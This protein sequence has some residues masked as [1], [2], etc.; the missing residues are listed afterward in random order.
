M[1]I[2]DAFIIDNLRRRPRE[3]PAAP[4]ELPLEL[5]VSE[6]DRDG[7]DGPPPQPRGQEEPRPRG[8]IVLDT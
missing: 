1:P 5:P 8:V 4:A 6:H 3:R 7:R 2:I